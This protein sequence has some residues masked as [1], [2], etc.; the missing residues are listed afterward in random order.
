MKANYLI[1]N[2]ITVASKLF[3]ER[4]FMKVYMVKAMEIVCFEKR[5][6]FANVK[7]TRNTTADDISDLSID[8]DGQLKNKIKGFIAFSVA[9]DTSTDFTNVAQPAI[10][11][12]RVADALAV[13][14]DF[15]KMVPML[16]TRTVV[17]VSLHSLVP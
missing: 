17:D 7:L 15:V 6:T 10:V 11:I 2:K 4:E 13:T 9:I 8:L 1:A 12:R 14:K 3:S 5:R 16:G